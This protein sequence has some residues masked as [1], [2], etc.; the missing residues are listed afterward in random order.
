MR[1]LSRWFGAIEVDDEL[2]APV[3]AC[4]TELVE[5]LDTVD[6]SRV[7]RLR[8][9]IHST[10]HGWTVPGGVEIH[11][12]HESDEMG[13]LDIVIGD[14][15][16]IVSWLCAH[17]HVFPEDGDHARPWPTVVVDLVA[18][19][20]R[21]EYEVQNHWRG[22]RLTKTRVV[23]VADPEGERV[24]SSTG[25]LFG[26]LPWPGPKRVEVQRLDFGASGPSS[27]PGP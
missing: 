6:P 24:I 2:A 15:E 12:A 23:D 27:L 9:A 10:G 25:P 21:G 14:R 11:L 20:I 4:L 18:A 8:S 26:W 19:A 1:R 5:M 7:D 13:D 17:E 22:K 16:A 3:V